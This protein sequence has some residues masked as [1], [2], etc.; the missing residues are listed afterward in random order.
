MQLTVSHYKMV[1]CSK[2]DTH[3]Q[4]LNTKMFVVVGFIAA[5]ALARCMGSTNLAWT[6]TATTP[7][8]RSHKQGKHKKANHKLRNYMLEPLSTS[9]V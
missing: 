2:I 5:I 9:L 3:N 6:V 1:K 4:L 7:N 8:I